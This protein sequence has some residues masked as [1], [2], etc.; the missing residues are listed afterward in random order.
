[1]TKKKSLTFQDARIRAN[2]VA[3]DQGLRKLAS[4]DNTNFLSDY[5]LEAEGCWY[6]FPIEGVTIPLECWHLRGFAVAVSKAGMVSTVYDF[7]DNEQ[8]MREYLEAFSLYSLG[9][10][11]EAKTAMAAFLSKYP[12]DSAA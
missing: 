11:D 12:S 8:K 6:F 2:E 7:R 10:K 1:M 5:Y 4:P 9:K 3:A